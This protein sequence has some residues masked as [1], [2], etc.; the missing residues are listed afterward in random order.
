MGTWFSKLKLS[1]KLA[2]VIIGVSLVGL[3]TYSAA[4]WYMQERAAIGHAVRT[5]SQA[6]DQF[7]TL[8]AGA[9]KWG[10]GDAVAETYKHYRDDPSLALV[11]F[12]AVNGSGETVNDWFDDASVPADARTAVAGAASADPETTDSVTDVGSGLLAITTALPK[13]KAGKS[14]GTVT[15]VWSTAAIVAEARNSAL[16]LLG[17]QALIMSL[18]VIVFLFA[19]RRLMSQPLR[20]LSDRIVAL[21]EGDTTSAVPYQANN[22]EIGVVARALEMFRTETIEKQVQEKSAAQEREA[23]NLERNRNAEEAAD[24]ARMQ[25]D[26]VSRLANALERLAG[27]DFS[28]RVDDLGPEFEKVAS[29]FNRMVGA[30]AAVLDE[31]KVTAGSIETG[32]QQLLQSAEQLSDRTARQAASLEETAASLEEITATVRRSSES[33]SEAGHLVGNTKEEAR[34]SVAKMQ[35]AIGAMDRIE[36]SSSQ[37]GRIIGVIDEIAFQTNLLA[38]NAGVEAAR[39]GEAGKGFAVVAQEVRELAQRSAE[40]AKEIKQLIATSVEEVE[41]GAALV[42]QTGSVLTEIEQQIG[43]I[44]ESIQGIMQSYGEQ[45]ASLS[46]INTAVS[47]MDQVTQQNAAMAEETNAASHDL[48]SQGDILK[49]AVARFVTGTASAGASARVARPAPQAV[50]PQVAA[51]AA[52]P[53]SVPVRASVGN[54]ALAEDWEEF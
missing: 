45:S 27:G 19:Q 2:G 8:A 46:E 41:T 30:V 53:S 7:A 35:D 47:Y 38:L 31:I 44:F 6:T 25:A 22:D 34:K 50:R 42:N 40:A 21:R 13:D 28:A 48:V 5:W 20:K 32:S 36:A 18:V 15:T 16:V 52:A 26:V 51:K 12:S 49:K 33:A 4:S 1:A 23:I 10:Q 43:M 9:V 17:S 29:D 54:A 11:G 39:A 24:K 14:I 37:I 3:L